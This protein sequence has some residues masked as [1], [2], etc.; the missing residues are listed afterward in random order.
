M[1]QATAGLMS[2]LDEIA[3]RERLPRRKEGGRARAAEEA[4]QRAANRLA[5]PHAWAGR[6]RRRVLFRVSALTT[7]AGGSRAGGRGASRSQ[8]TLPRGAS[9][10]GTRATL[11]G[12]RRYASTSP[13]RCTRPRSTEARPACVHKLPRP[14]VRLR[15][16]ASSRRFARRPPD[17]RFLRPRA[18]SPGEGRLR[19]VRGVFR[20]PRNSSAADERLYVDIARAPPAHPRPRLRPGRH[21]RAPPRGPGRGAW[22]GPRPGMVERSRARDARSRAIRTR[23]SRCG[24]RLFSGQSSRRSDQAPSVRG[25]RP[26]RSPK[27]KLAPG[28]TIARRSTPSVDAYKVSGSTPP[29]GR[30]TPPRSPRPRRFPASR[31]A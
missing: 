18:P 29:A 4:S 3:A 22:R 12:G 7:F 15:P 27:A 30:R 8:W 1:G 21:S 24:R 28:V 26:L 10:S 14:P 23:F 17:D 25:A 9:P 2:R 16:R 31:P 11:R 5:R 13:K 6:L 20:A 19:R